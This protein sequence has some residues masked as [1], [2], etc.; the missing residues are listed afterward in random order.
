M[1]TLDL[2]KKL[3]TEIS[4]IALLEWE[5]GE[6]DPLNKKWQVG[7]IIFLIICS[8]FFFLQKNYFGIILALIIAF[9]VF[10]SPKQKKN[11]Y[12][13]LTKKGVRIKNENF[14]WKNLESFWI[15]ENTTEIYL[16]S[17]KSYFPYIILPLEKQNINTAR[18]ILL[19]Y[20]PEEEAEKN[21]FD[22]IS[23]KLGL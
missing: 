19:N 8:L 11:N 6:K 18:N 10:F 3:E 2:K 12:Y 13:A 23:R 22:I 21:L 16:K 7:I 9:L 1:K 20:L 5:N 14:P 15:F 4:E 17:K